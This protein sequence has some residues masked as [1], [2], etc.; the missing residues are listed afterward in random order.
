MSTPKPPIGKPTS[1]KFGGYVLEERIASGGT[2]DVFLARPAS[3]S[4]PAPQLVIKRLLPSLRTDAN[5]RS[6]FTEEA[7]LH[8]RFRH[9]NIVECYEAG[10]VDGEPF[11][12]IELVAGADLHRVLDLS[13]TRKRPIALALATYVARE[14]LAAL[15]VVHGTQGSGIVH[16]DVSP[17]NI[18][19]SN[20][21]DV[22]L[23]DFGIAREASSRSGRGGLATTIKGKFAYLAPEQV[24]SEPVDHR[25]DLFALANVLSEMMLG[26][27]LF[28]GS[29]QLAVLLSIRDVRIEALDAPSAIP[30][31][32]V[33]ILRRALAR[34]P[35]HRFPD[36]ASFA[37]ALEP[38][39]TRDRDAARRDIAQLVRWTRQTSQELRAVGEHPEQR[40]VEPI[41]RSAQSIRPAPAIHIDSSILEDDEITPKPPEPVPSIVRRP[42]EP[43]PPSRPSMPPPQPAGADGATA[44][45]TPKPS[46]VRTVDGRLLGPF[47][48]AKLIEL[49]V[50]GR[51]DADDHVDFLGAGFQ[52][53]ADIDELARHLAPRSS[54]TRQVEG[55][56]TPDFQGFA[57]ERYDEEV[58]GA[59]EPGIATAMGFAASRRAT[60]VLLA[61][62]GGRRKEIYF[63]N[64]RVF[65]VAS[66]EAAEMIGEYL[67]ARGL[68]QR[69]D[70][71]FALAVLPRFD[72]RLGE[73]IAGLGLLEPVKMFKAIEEQG[74]DKIVEVF[75]WSDG[76]ISFYSGGQP[77][78]VEF[79][80]D[81][82]IGPIVEAGM[83][84]MLDEAHAEARYAA[85]L[86]RRIR[87]REVPS[88]L[89]DAG[90][91]PR[92]ERALLSL[93]QPTRVGN[94]LDTLQADGLSKYEAILAVE[95]ARVAGLLDWA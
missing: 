6:T 3:G 61:Q 77:G 88:S 12:A 81:L 49:V 38:F 45:F 13:R 89:R 48:Y 67:V 25:A 24:A 83:A 54:V 64:G 73:A 28:A 36:A 10:E 22:K 23:G 62:H 56:G 31:P 65:H 21:G 91:S 37:S 2:A 35:A 40:V 14:V 87:P 43:P 78:K 51:L 1:R 71:D 80:L 42:P 79:P 9:P 94:V 18:Y 16:R 15:E 72:G 57:A 11:L 68:L 47:A 59:I 85:W 95:S 17:S 63:V 60:G 5:A 52:P 66:T 30:V 84:N 69:D 76:E 34:D 26:R 4:S 93:K 82:P 20:T 86:E 70:L 27:P 58:G 90:W 46:Y 44:P 8:R 74:R 39:A 50:T 75:G 29:G 19:L 7:A 41:I 55:P 32:L 33:A 92:V 53:L